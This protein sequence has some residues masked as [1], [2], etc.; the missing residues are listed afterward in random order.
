MIKK[1]IIN[2]TN[3]TTTLDKERILLIIRWVILTSIFIWWWVTSSSSF[4]VALILVLSSTTLIRMQFSN[5]FW[6]I[7]IE[8]VACLISTQYFPGAVFA[9]LL[10]AFESGI[11]GY[12]LTFIPVFLIIFL[13]NEQVNL[14]FILIL[15]LMVY[16]IGYILKAWSERENIYLKAADSERK[17]RY[18][19]ELFKNELLLANNEVAKLVEATERNRIAQ[20]LHDNVGHEITGALIAIQAY[21]KLA[22]SNDKRAEEMLENVLKR[23]E[24][25]SIKL[26]ETVYQLRP[27]IEGGALRLQRLCEEFTF[28]TIKYRFLGDKDRVPAMAWVILEPCLK[29]AFTNISKY[30][31]ATV[32]DVSFDI[33]SYIIRMFIKDNGVG[34]KKINSGLGLFGIKERIRAAG[35][36]VS[37]DG[38]NGF[39]IT[40]I[41]PINIY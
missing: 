2:K 7:I 3:T 21:K 37:I 28:C 4:G 39:M 17:Q 35:G 26:R 36:T 12:L 22:E 34:A 23:I 31:Q 33:T 5:S 38:T 14:V 6:L 32:V 19:I 10:P 24:S 40:C 9:M 18:E 11:R 20:Q 25:S 8:E 1:F 15:N 13:K 41:L 29:E 27:S 16:S 30:S